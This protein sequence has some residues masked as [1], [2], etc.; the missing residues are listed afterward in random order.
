MWNAG[1]P[2]MAELS[3]LGLVR[4]IDMYGG[5]DKHGKGRWRTWKEFKQYYVRGELGKARATRLAAA[6]NKLIRDE[7]IQ[8]TEASRWLRWFAERAEG[9]GPVR[10]KEEVEARLLEERKGY[11]CEVILGA[12]ETGLK[13]GGEEYLCHYRNHEERESSWL[14]RVAVREIW[15]RGATWGQQRGEGAGC[16]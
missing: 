2:L 8:P 10:E 12:K 9:D 6:Y 3:R 11:S 1:Q 4:A 15:R 16:G 5:R 14:Q 13:T 7:E